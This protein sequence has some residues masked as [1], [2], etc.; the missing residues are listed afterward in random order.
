MHR[1]DSTP[2]RRAISASD[3]PLLGG[4][5]W[6]FASDGGIDSGGSDGARDFGATD[7]GAREGGA[8]DSGASEGMAEGGGEK[9]GGEDG[10]GDAGAQLVKSRSPIAS[11]ATELSGAG[12][13]AFSSARADRACGFAGFTSLGGGFLPKSEKTTVSSEVT[14]ATRPRMRM[15]AESSFL[16]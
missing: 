16:P 5:L 14:V 2:R 13:L 6:P 3:R 8:I 10:G 12:A 15:P 11:G 9:D 7:S 1:F 4:T